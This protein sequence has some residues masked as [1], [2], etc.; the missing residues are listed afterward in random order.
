MRARAAARLWGTAGLTL[1]LLTPVAAATATPSGAHTATA[2]RATAA[3][4][5]AASSVLPFDDYSDM[6]VDGVHSR[7]FFSDPTRGAV[8]V[9]D[10]DGT[11]LKQVTGLSGAAQLA[12]SQDAATLYAALPGADTV[13]AVSTT[14]HKV[15]ARYATGAG[16]APRTL[17]VSGKHLWFGYG[18]EGAGDIGSVDLTT[19]HPVVTLG[20]ATGD[21]WYSAPALATSAAA[22][23]VLVAG[24]RD[25]SPATFAVYDVH[26]ATARRTAERRLPDSGATRDLAFTADGKSIIVASGSPYYHQ[27]LRTSDLTDAG[28]YP[29]AAY[30]NAVAVAADGTVAAGV[31]SSHGSDVFMFKPGARASHGVFEFA[32][33][34][35]SPLLLPAGL[36]W[37][38]DNRRLFAVTRETRQGAPVVLRVLTT[39]GKAAT[40]TVLH[41]PSTTP[42]ALAPSPAVS[43]PTCPSR[44][45][46]PS[47]SPA[48]T[49]V[50]R[51]R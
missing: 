34:D 19:A 46:L 43:P 10:F 2:H 25:V 37:A 6:V 24:E 9:T 45:V 13:A 35:S 21:S 32:S 51:S 50:P 12:L 29:A 11:V 38:P 3:Q 7:L 28:R 39:P 49:R 16:T 47:P 44:P 48:W 15:L 31:D 1:A 27:L 14:T 40:E 22:P 5:H 4:P 23:G 41:I 26:T 36:A 20:Q 18:A 17:A 42:P 30:P 8:V 33:G